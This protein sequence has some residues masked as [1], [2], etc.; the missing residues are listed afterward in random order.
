VQLDPKLSD[1]TSVL[2]V[3]GVTVAGLLLVVSFYL[4]WEKNKERKKHDIEI[5][6]LIKK[7][8]SESLENKKSLIDLVTR[9]ILAAEQNAQAINNIKDVLYNVR[10]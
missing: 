4:I 5:N 3:E 1:V 8:D 7:L 9:S 2:S 10:K 6:N